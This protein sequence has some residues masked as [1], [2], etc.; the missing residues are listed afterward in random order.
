LSFE[1]PTVLALSFL[2]PIAKRDNRFLLTPADTVFTVCMTVA[3]CAVG[4]CVGLGLLFFWM[5]S[6]F[7]ER[8]RIHVTSGTLF[9]CCLGISPWCVLFACGAAPLCS[10]GLL[11]PPLHESGF[12]LAPS[13]LWL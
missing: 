6:I 3:I 1:R 10:N 9:L 12:L 8:S 4:D 7:V 5:A 2:T 13:Y 11:M